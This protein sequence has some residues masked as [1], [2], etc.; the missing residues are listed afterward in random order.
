MRR[1][2]KDNNEMLLPKTRSTSSIMQGVMN[3]PMFQQAVSNA[4]N[5][6]RDK[7]AVGAQNQMLG[8][9]VRQE[10]G[11]LEKLDEAGYQLASRRD[12]LGFQRQIAAKRN[13]LAQDQ[14]KTQEKSNK[15]AMTLGGLSTIATGFGAVSGW[16]NRRDATTR[17][18]ELM[19]AFRTQQPSTYTSRIDPWR[20]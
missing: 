12:R 18:D 11:R 9:L 1:F 13:I 17:H 2:I 20:F 8:G 7:R 19:D 15:L 10:R 4:G 3:Q 6:G 5:I 16:R 14:L